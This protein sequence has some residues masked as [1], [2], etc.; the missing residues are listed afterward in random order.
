[1][2]SITITR[3]YEQLSS[4][5]GKETAENLITFIEQKVGEEME[6]NQKSLSDRRENTNVSDRLDNSKVQKKRAFWDHPEW[7]FFI[8]CLLVSV[9]VLALAI[10]NG[11]K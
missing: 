8:C 7:L 1:M 11:K 2:N 4:K 9:I 6:N 5:L 10:I 3:L